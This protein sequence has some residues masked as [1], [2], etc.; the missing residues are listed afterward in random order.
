MPTVPIDRIALLAISF[1]S[2]WLAVAVY[3]RALDR[4]WNRL[5]AIHA[6]AVG[7][8]VFFNYL[9]Q[10]AAAAQAEPNTTLWL[11][12]ALPVV[13]LVICTCV[14]F[15]WV[16][17]EQI[18]PP[19]WP[20]RAILYA[21]GLVF[22]L[23]AFAPELFTSLS[24]AHGTV[25]LAYGPPYTAFGIFTVVML[26]YADY[27]M[28]G[29]L[30][31]LTGVQRV[32]VMYV[33]GGLLS[34]Q[35]IAIVT[36]MLLPVVWENGVYTRWGSAGYIF[37]IV[38]MAYAL[39]KEHIA[40]PK[41]AL[42]RVV[43]LLFVV[44]PVLSIAFIALTLSEFFIGTR[45]QYL[46]LA[47]MLTGLFMGF[48]IYPL[49]TYVSEV[50][51]GSDPTEQKPQEAFDLSTEAILRTLDID[52]LLERSVEA[53]SEMLQP[54]RVSIFLQDEDTQDYLC[55]VGR[56]GRDGQGL[57]ANNDFLP[58]RHMVVR[59][60]AHS[61]DIINRDEIFRFRSLEVAKPLAEALDQLGAQMVAPLRWED[62]LIGLILVSP[63]RTG[64]MYQREQIEQLRGMIP[65]ISLAL[66]NANLYAEVT[67]TKEYIETILR[68][69]DSGVIAAGGDGRIF[70]YNRAAERMVGVSREKVINHDL[71]VLPTGIARGLRTAVAYKRTRAGDRFDLPRP[72]HNS[73]PIACSTSALTSV[74]GQRGGAVA[75]IND[76]TVIQ[77][78]E[79]ERQ[80]AERLELMRVLT[81]GMAHEIRNPLV[82]IRTFA[83]LLPTRL[84]D[85]EF[86]STFL[87][88]ATAEIEQINNLVGQLLS[89]SKPAHATNEVIKVN[90]VCQSIVRS[91][92]AQAEAKQISLTV[93]LGDISGGPIGDERRLHQA[94]VNLVNNALE[95]EPQGGTVQITTEQTDTADDGDRVLIQV[96]NSGSYIPPGKV[97][98]IFKPFYTDKAGG[99][100]LGL[101]ICQT[102]IEEHDGTL[103]AHSRPDTGTEFV[104]ELPLVA[105]ARDDDGRVIE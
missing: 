29:K 96:H 25:I 73:I 47:Y 45:E 20:Q 74:A 53:I 84:D 58:Q 71:E 39:T 90:E 19:P 51:A 76:L 21:A 63:N 2:L 83:E 28:Y 34:S 70:L 32:Q 30:R 5:Y 13:A 9:I 91:A 24:F 75:V 12:L 78:L 61:H 62:E 77:Q 17:P 85:E 18:S 81:A 38:A 68:E 41:V 65:L 80:R 89:L 52:E 57:P 22:S 10:S 67:S 48:A 87:A 15:A 26:G 37:T 43:A 16:F 40:G 66:Q 35:A 64:E 1:A 94:I 98:K 100:G 103:E 59:A 54:D 3:R 14:D 55:R 44:V 42:R 93:N 102:I 8:W 27:V 49:H 105:T 97:D 69:M 79:D 86:R 6:M 11:R 7:T 82:A 4:V 56:A 23:V 95:A 92:S 36:M 104:I 31:R 101:A 88:T 99:T 72:G 46:V 33:L 50:I 60:A